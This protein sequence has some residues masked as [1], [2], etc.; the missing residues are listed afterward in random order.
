MKMVF[1]GEI[2]NVP[3]DLGYFV[4]NRPSDEGSISRYFSFNEWSVE[5]NKNG[6]NRG[7]V[8]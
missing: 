3:V 2:I 7:M 8:M 1:K 5:I 4:E 6:F